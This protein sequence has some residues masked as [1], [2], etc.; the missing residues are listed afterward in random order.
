MTGA[1]PGGEAENNESG[2][3]G[4]PPQAFRRMDEGADTAFY[5]PPR[6][7]T[8]IDQGAIAA[9]TALYTRIL[10]PGAEVLDLMTS[11]VSHL[12]EGVKLGRVAGLGMNAVELD[13][14]PRLD[15][16][17]IADLNADPALPW[18]DA[19]FD[20]VLV[21]V[22]VQYLTRPVSVLG[23]VARV[24]R[25]GGVVAITFSNRCFPTK[26]VMIWQ[27]AGSGSDR[28]R[29]VGHCLKAAGLGDVAAEALVPEGGP[30][31]PLWAV[32][33]RRPG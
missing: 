19:S 33:A 27:V 29:Y 22:S 26:A 14:N 30:G 15:E 23:E 1:P 24:L 20:A 16:R 12:P 10:A 32:T 9:V 7:V 2:L 25:P 17:R 21:C 28:A 8:H 4:L 18:A 13:A 31:D 6:L 11:W 3:L 5:L